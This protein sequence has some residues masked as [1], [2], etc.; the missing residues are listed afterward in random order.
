MF[1]ADTGGNE[2]AVL[3]NTWAVAGTPADPSAV[4]LV[5]TDPAGAQVTY[6]YGGAG[7]ITKVSTGK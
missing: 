5:V 1:F 2:L 7:T 4:S 3:T 6:T